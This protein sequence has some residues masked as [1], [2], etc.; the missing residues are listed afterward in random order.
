VENGLK[1]E[2]KSYLQE[3]CIKSELSNKIVERA[4]NCNQLRLSFEA[5]ENDPAEWEAMIEENNNTILK[6][7]LPLSF[8]GFGREEYY[9]K[10]IRWG[11]MEGGVQTKQFIISFC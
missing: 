3:N 1:K 9:S 7:I 11:M 5:A 6:S 4:K 2:G 10:C 8:L